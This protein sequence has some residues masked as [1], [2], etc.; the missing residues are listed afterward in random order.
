MLDQMYKKYKP[1]GFTLIGVNVDKEEPAVK[2]LVDLT[3]GD[4]F[5][6]LENMFVRAEDNSLVMVLKDGKKFTPDVI[7]L[8][9]RIA[10]GLLSKEQMKAVDVVTGGNAFVNIG[11]KPT[12]TGADTYSAM[13]GS[14][15]DLNN[16]RG[17][18]VEVL[19]RAYSRRG[20]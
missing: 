13:D 10:C 6:E 11:I 19:E 4:N 12:A 1:A 7:T 14:P 9:A 18:L 8:L 15:A 5:G 2:E 17:R 3:K 16:I 20:L